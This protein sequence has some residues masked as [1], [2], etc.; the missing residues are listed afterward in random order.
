MIRTF[1][2]SAFVAVGMSS[3]TVAALVGG[4]VC[5]ALSLAPT[6]AVAAAR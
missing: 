2:L 3:C 1:L 6:P 5:A 4:P